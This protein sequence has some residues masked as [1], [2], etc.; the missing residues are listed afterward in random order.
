VKHICRLPFEQ[1]PDPV[2]RAFNKL[3]HDVY[4]LMQGPSEF[5]IA[6]LL[7][8]WDRSKDLPKIAVPTLVVGAQYD[9]M[10]PEHMKWMSTQVQQG[11]YLYCP[12]GSHLSMYDDQETY[13][14]GV[15][16][17]IIAVDAGEKT[18]ALP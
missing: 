4:V 9:T 17:F 8:T 5:G 3:N 11:S 14:Q 18:V 15:I 7:T 13:I 16:K 10:D 2:M 12:N 6:G 1:W